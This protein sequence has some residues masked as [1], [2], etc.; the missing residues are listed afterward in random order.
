MTMSQPGASRST[1]AT[2][3]IASAQILAPMSHRKS[4]VFV[5]DS[6]NVIYLSK[7]DPAVVGSGI[8][9]N[10]LGGSYWEP[11]QRFRVWPDNWYAIATLA[12]SNLCITEDW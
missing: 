10:A 7:T 12:A 9:L 3:G 11:D 1:F 8:R 6:A 2:V 4:V 5:N